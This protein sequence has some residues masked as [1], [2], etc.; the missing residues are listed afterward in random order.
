MFTHKLTYI[1][2]EHNSET[3]IPMRRAKVNIL[4]KKPEHRWVDNIK[5]VPEVT[6]FG[7]MDAFILDQDR[8]R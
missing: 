8:N 2:Q 4:L 1:R 6:V 3:N 7:S 5:T